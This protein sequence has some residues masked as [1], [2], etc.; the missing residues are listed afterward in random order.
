M[1]LETLWERL[2][3]GS[4]RIVGHGS[5]AE[6][7]HLSVDCDPNFVPGSA[8]PEPR[9][10]AV[11]QALL[12]G[13]SRMV[14]ALECGM[15]PSAITRAAA[16][17]LRA[18][19][20]AGSLRTVPV[21]LAA[22]AHAAVGVTELGQIVGTAS[23]TDGHSMT[24]FHLPRVEAGLENRLGAVEFAAVRLC[25]EGPPSLS[26][27]ARTNRLPRAVYAGRARA[28][29]K[30][31]V[32][33]RLELIS[34]LLKARYGTPLRGVELAP[35]PREAAAQMPRPQPVACPHCTSNEGPF[36]D[37]RSA[38]LCRTCARTFTTS[39]EPIRV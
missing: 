24:T 3:A 26:P 20:E 7:F 28:F 10:L 21:V 23:V 39:G 8:S 38:W 25:L 36:R 37:L 2:R 6:A 15:T 35:S 29:R 9:A 30:L 12:L 33:G 19:G 14:V 18:F 4:V 5:S 22:A 1:D 11:L 31:G 17:V 34:Y 16:G 27:D 32:G 13:R